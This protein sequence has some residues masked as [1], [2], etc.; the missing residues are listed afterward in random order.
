MVKNKKKKKIVKEMDVVKIYTSIS[1]FK[2]LNDL[3]NLM[4]VCFI[5]NILM[6][7]VINI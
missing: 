4:F 6:L 1:Y 7:I 2:K 5:K 3:C